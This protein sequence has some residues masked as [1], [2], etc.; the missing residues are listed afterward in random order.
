MT[1]SGLMLLRVFRPVP[2]KAV[3]PAASGEGL[4]EQ[5]G[6]ERPTAA[7]CKGLARAEGPWG[8]PAWKSGEEALERTEM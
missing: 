3:L 4:L 1:G 6:R 8:T 2:R 7:L 5:A